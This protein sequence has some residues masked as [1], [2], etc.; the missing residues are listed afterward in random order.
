M[1]RM[2]VVPLPNLHASNMSGTSEGERHLQITGCSRLAVLAI[3]CRCQ[4]D[5]LKEG[6]YP[7]DTDWVVVGV[8][9]DVQACR[10]KAS[11][12]TLL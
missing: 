11:L 8:V 10:D 9:K 4:W 1:Q 12:T 5:L 6:I 7:P 3:A 2:A